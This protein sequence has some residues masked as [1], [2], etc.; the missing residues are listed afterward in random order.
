MVRAA[1]FLRLAHLVEVAT[2]PQ[3]FAL[4]FFSRILSRLLALLPFIGFPT[5]GTT[6]FLITTRIEHHRAAPAAALGRCFLLPAALGHRGR[7]RCLR[8]A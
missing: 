1:K 7:L 2:A 5:Y 4:R 8:R 6:T 3:A